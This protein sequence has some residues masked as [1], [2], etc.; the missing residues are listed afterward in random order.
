MN[1]ALIGVRRIGVAELDQ[2]ID[3]A[4]A[5]L[6]GAGGDAVDR[7]E[8]AR[9]RVDGDV[10]PFGL[11]VALVDRDQ[12]RRRRAF[13]LEVER[14]FDRGLGARGGPPSSTAAARMSPAW[15]EPEALEH[16]HVATPWISVGPNGAWRR[17][18]IFPAQQRTC[19]M[20][21]QG[22]TAARAVG[23]HRRPIFCTSECQS[24]DAAGNAAGAGAD[25][26]A[27][28]VRRSLADPEVSDERVQLRAWDGRA[29]L[30]R[31]LCAAGRDA[32]AGAPGRGIA[33]RGRRGPHRCPRPAAGREH[34]RPIPAASAASRISCTPIRFRP[35]RAWR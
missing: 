32:G 18:C 34:P 10:E 1:T 7:L 29:G 22:R 5:H 24:A 19:R 21:E 14:E 33:R 6:V 27:I 25:R 20:K 16:V 23:L 30:C 31:A 11:E 26:L 17:A 35:R 4:E 12:E 8:R 28:S 15:S 3:V 2:R 13:E 9:R